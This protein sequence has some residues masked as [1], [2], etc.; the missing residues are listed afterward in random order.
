LDRFFPEVH[1][2][3]CFDDFPQ[4]TQFAAAHGLKDSQR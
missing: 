2:V 3:R 1:D 4:K